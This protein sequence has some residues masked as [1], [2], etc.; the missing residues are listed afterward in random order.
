MVL[1]VVSE[2][3]PWWLART[4]LVSGSSI[5][6]EAVVSRTAPVVYLTGE[7]HAELVRVV[8]A[9]TSEQ[10]MVTRARLALLAA[11]GVPNQEIGERVGMAAKNVAKW[12]RRFLAQGLSGLHDRPRPGGPCRYRHDDR[13]RVFQTACSPPPEGASQWTVRSLAA[14]VSIGKS[15]VLELLDDAS[16]KPHLVRSWL[17]SIDPQFETKRADVC[18]L[19]LTPPENAI[20]ISID[21]KTAIAARPPV[22]PSL[23]I[24]PGKPERR[25]FEYRRDGTV[26]LLAG[27]L[28][29]T[30]EIHGHVYERHSRVEF[31]DFLTQLENTV[32]PGK[33]IHAVLDNLQV[34]KTAEVSTWLSEHPRWTLHFT[35]THASWLNQIELWFSILSRRLLKR[36]I[37]TSRNDLTEKLESFITTYNETAQPFA[38]TYAGKP[39]TI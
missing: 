7:E 26:A 38:W 4:G 27:L 33:Q 34:H 30:G 10:R 15:R 29:H 9:P 14:A 31:I 35:P 2:K 20:V 3:G 21:E 37:F 24:E 25:E 23:P 13:L 5:T 36:G 17:T 28:V 6:M 39:L 32:Q 22:R 19:Y 8:N 16:L 12:R 11:D 18:G 1:C